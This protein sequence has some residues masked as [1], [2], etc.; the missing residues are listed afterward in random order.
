MHVVSFSQK[1]ASWRKKKH[2]TAGRANQNCPYIRNQSNQNPLKNLAQEINQIG[3]ASGHICF[4]GF[5][6]NP[7]GR[8]LHFPIN[9][10]LES[11]ERK[12]HLELGQNIKLEH[13]PN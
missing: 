11:P 7:A 10:S 9:M 13:H 3:G 5:F 8:S 12:T 6:R 1:V 2:M 4:S